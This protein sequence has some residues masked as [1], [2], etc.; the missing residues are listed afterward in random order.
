MPI[1]I[2]HDHQFTVE[3]GLYVVEGQRSLRFYR[4]LLG[5]ELFAT[6]EME[7]RR[8]WGLRM[9]NSCIK[10]VEYDTPFLERDP[11][12]KAIGIRYITIHATEV[13]RIY[14]R[15]REQGYEI[16][17]PPT[18][19]PE[20]PGRFGECEIILVRDPDGNRVEICKGSPWIEV[21]PESGRDDRSKP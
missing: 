12:G 10:L 11:L 3:T 6:F 17:S 7:D 18:V 15:C 1:A 13:R 4:D 19:L 14:E 21:P 9:G 2:D 20:D 5:F 16:L 8:V